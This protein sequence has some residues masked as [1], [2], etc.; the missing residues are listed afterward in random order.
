MIQTT[1]YN[2]SIPLVVWSKNSKGGGEWV[3][4]NLTPPPPPPLSN[5]CNVPGHY[6]FIPERHDLVS[7]SNYLWF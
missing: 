4:V 7:V 6:L 2:Y 5:F 1:T 3:N